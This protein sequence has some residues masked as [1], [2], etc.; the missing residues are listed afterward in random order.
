MSSLALSHSTTAAPANQPVLKLRLDQGED[1][2]TITPN[3]AISHGDV[4]PG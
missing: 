1:A 2:G 3:E 4:L